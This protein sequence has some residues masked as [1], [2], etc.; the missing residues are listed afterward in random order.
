MRWAHFLTHVIYF[1]QILFLILQ[2]VSSK[3]TAWRG[4]WA[5]LPWPGPCRR[6]RH[7]E[8]LAH[9][10]AAP[11]LWDKR[12]GWMQRPRPGLKMGGVGWSRSMGT[13]KLS[14]NICFSFPAFPD[15]N[16]LLVHSKD[17]SSLFYGK[18]HFCRSQRHFFLPKPHTKESDFF[19]Y[20]FTINPQ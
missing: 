16:I 11:E 12:R 13:G 1:A 15:K 7:T 19:V 8:T 20:I 5:E 2:A 3:G 10:W 6:A 18:T 4:T 9:P 14:W 17:K